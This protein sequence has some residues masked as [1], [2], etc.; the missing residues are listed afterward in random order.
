MNTEIKSALIKQYTAGFD[1]VNKYLTDF[2]AEKLTAKP[3]P[4]KW[5]AVEIVHHLADNEMNSAL[6]L[7]KLLAEEKPIIIGYDQDVFAEKMRY[8]ERPLNPSLQAFRY[9]RES[10]LQLIELM[11]DA[12]WKRE[13]WHTESGI[14]T[15]ETWL[16]IYAAHAHGHAAQIRRL[17]E[18]LTALS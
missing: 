11:S 17:R 13:G 16:E 8:N 14:Y 2:P 4:G 5:S 15:P 1:E 7:R 9:A 6:R 12:D 10:C 18:F 3:F